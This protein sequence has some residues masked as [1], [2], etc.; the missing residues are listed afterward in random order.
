M[1]PLHSIL[2]THVNKYHNMKKFI[3]CALLLS[4]TAASAQTIIEVRTAAELRS[5]LTSTTSGRVIRVMNDIAAGSWTP[6]NISG[7]ANGTFTLDGQGYVL[8]F[9]VTVNNTSNHSTYAGMIGLFDASTANATIRNF[10]IPL[11][12]YTTTGALVYHAI[13]TNN[14]TDIAIKALG[15]YVIRNGENVVRVVISD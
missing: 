1:L 15:I 10:G 8:S 3:I 14:E 4:V 6:V 12:V 7:V 9:T 5:A 2:I 13:A 11:S